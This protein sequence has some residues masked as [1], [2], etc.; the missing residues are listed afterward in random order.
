M[1]ADRSVNLASNF[2][3]LFLLKKRGREGILRA[4]KP[5]EPV[6]SPRPRPECEERLCSRE[7]SMVLIPGGN[8]Y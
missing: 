4:M 8:W 5:L 7:P 2:M 3:Y 6:P 1:Q